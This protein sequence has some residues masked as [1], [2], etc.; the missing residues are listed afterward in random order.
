MSRSRFDTCA[1]VS[2]ILKIW[3]LSFNDVSRASGFSKQYLGMLLGWLRYITSDAT[4]SYGMFCDDVALCLTSFRKHIKGQH[5]H[6][7]WS[8]SHRLSCWVHIR[9][10]QMS[11]FLKQYLTAIITEYIC[12]IVL[13]TEGYLVAN[14][15]AYLS[16]PQCLNVVPS[17]STHQ[18]RV[19]TTPSQIEASVPRFQEPP[20]ADFWLELSSTHKLH[21]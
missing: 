8:V 18:C 5:V 6:R 14:T 4:V 21:V 9:T 16:S 3:V 13:F 10:L 1:S 11:C 15:I 20:T 2:C 12:V 19:N 17:I 7:S